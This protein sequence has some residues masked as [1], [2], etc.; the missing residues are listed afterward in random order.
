MAHRKQAS[1][2]ERNLKD[3]GRPI[4]RDPDAAGSMRSKNER[5]PCVACG[6]SHRSGEYCYALKEKVW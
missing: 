3:L 5:K 4:K 2:R 1:K 6:G